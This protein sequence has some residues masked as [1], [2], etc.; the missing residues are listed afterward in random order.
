MDDEQ[1]KIKKDDRK[2][3]PALGWNMLMQQT[4]AILSGSL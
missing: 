1:G 4:Q 3:V 2:L